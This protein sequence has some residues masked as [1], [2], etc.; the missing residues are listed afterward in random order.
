MWIPDAYGL[1][2]NNRCLLIAVHRA[3]GEAL[4]Q[5]D[6]GKVSRREQIALISKAWKC[7]AAGEPITAEALK[8]HCMDEA[9]TTVGGIDIGEAKEEEAS[10]D[11][12]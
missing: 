3:H 11:N 8:L 1:T 7:F 2:H 10:E 4:A 5:N 6:D 12:E 9:P